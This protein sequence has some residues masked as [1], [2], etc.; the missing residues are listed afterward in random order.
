MRHF[1]EIDDLSPDE[2]TEVLDL[3]GEQHPAKVLEGRGV[4]LIFETFPQSTNSPGIF[5]V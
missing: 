2:L 5:R 1:L 4:A 3:A